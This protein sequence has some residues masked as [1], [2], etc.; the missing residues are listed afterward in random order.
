M[1]ALPFL[2][3]WF[4]VMFPLVY[5]PGPANTL[6]AS[7][8]AQFGFKRSIPFLVG[9]DVAFVLQSLLAGFGISEMLV[10][11]PGLFTLMRYLGIAYIAW[12]GCMFL[13]AAM[14]NKPQQPNCLSFWDGMVVTFINPKAWVMQI[15][16]FTQFL[17]AGDALASSVIQLTLLLS[18]LNIS[19][20]VVWILFGSVLLSRA[21][22]AFSAR[23]QNGMYAAMLFGSIYFLI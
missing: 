18:V 19:G 14:S 11:F 10:L 4:L 9:I 8:G 13:G 3:T 15:M 6:F 1:P 16:M 21:A 20:H 2:T 22:H 17:E 12:L 7:N 23:M 5:S